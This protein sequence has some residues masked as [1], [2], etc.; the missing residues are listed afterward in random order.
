MNIIHR[1]FSLMLLLLV[2]FLA[3]SEESASKDSEKPAAGAPSSLPFN[4]EVMKFAVGWEFVNAG[5]ATMHFHDRQ[6]SEYQIDIDA[7][8]NSFFDIFKKVRDSMISQ[9]VFINGNPQ[10]TLFDLEQNERSY[11]AIKKTRFLWEKDKVVYTHNKDTKE[12]DVPA[13][14]LNVID[15]FYKTRTLPVEANK[16]LKIPV[17]DSGKRYEI[18]VRLL[19]REKLRAPWGKRVDCLVIEPKLK[20]EGIFSSVGSMKIWLT[21]DERRIPLK[22]TAK[23]KIG[24][25]VARLIGYQAPS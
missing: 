9:G 25:I 14:H 21:D 15:A 22:M 5:T 20:S 17:F 6:N 3:F 23:I 7:R 18:E 10:S 12:F 11:H 1:T 19:K 16:I 4:N 24:H 8:T 2:P 13:G